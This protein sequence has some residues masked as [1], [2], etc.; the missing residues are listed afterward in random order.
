MYYG[1]RKASVYDPQDVK[2]AM[3]SGSSLGRQIGTE[4]DKWHGVLDAQDAQARAAQQRQQAQQAQQAQ[5]EQSLQAA[6]Q[7]RRAYESETNRMGQSQKY[8]L[9]GGLLSGGMGGM[10]GMKRTFG[11]RPAS[12]R[13]Y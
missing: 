8:S 13:R 7:Q 2:S 3:W 6:E 12:Q 4:M 9:L 11:D 10:G 1:P 5:H